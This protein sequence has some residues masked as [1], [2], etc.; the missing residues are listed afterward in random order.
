M[1]KE[2]HATERIDPHGLPVDAPQ[3]LRFDQILDAGA[4]LF[5]KYGFAR[6]LT[7]D[8]ATSAGITKRTLYR[9]VG[10]KQLLLFAVCSQLSR[11][12]E[13]IAV[14]RTGDPGAQ[15]REIITEVAE[16]VL[17]M[18]KV[19]L[20]YLSERKHFTEQQKQFVQHCEDR[21]VSALSNALPEPDNS[22]GND[23]VARGI[24]GSLL[25]MAKWYRP[26]G[27][28]SAE[29]LA[30][31]ATRLWTEGVLSFGGIGTSAP[32]AIQAQPRTSSDFDQAGLLDWDPMNETQHR[33]LDVATDMFANAGFDSTSTRH[34]AETAKLTKG[35]LHYYI[36]RKENLLLQIHFR[37]MEASV[38]ALTEVKRQL[39]KPDEEI[40]EI[41]RLHVL[42]V[43]KHHSAIV[44]FNEE[45]KALGEDGMERIAL[46]RTLYARSLEATIAALLSD[47]ESAATQEEVRVANLLLLGMLN[48]VYRWFGDGDQLDPAAVSATLTRLFTGGAISVGERSSSG[49]L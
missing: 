41:I 45:S 5:D 18:H 17:R 34:L 25:H 36:E 22:A 13:K 26:T 27:R 8:I 43:R 30:E 20:V 21:L 33:I 3:S 12:F 48:S 14:D 28:L 15:V 19:V 23:I 10:S 39:L 29:S 37:V 44:V 7:E 40:A 1:H 46:W 6:T 9:Y 11:G 4:E 47:H 49:V 32:H 16:I 38:Q 31:T 2:S 24:V 42:N 35:S